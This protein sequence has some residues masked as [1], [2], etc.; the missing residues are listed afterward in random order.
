MSRKL[1]IY[2]AIVAVFLLFLSLNIHSNK[3]PANYRCEIHADKAGYYVYLPAL[4]LYDFNPNKFPKNIENTIGEGFAF[5]K[6]NPENDQKV[7]FTKYPCG[8]A[9]M[10][11][12][13]FLATHFFCTISN[14]EANGFSIP[15]HRMRD[16]ATCFYTIAGLF[17]VLLT[18]S[19]KTKLTEN[20]IILGVT[21]FILGTNFLYYSVKDVGL[22]HN[23]SFFLIALFVY[24]YTI[25]FN[26]Q[27]NYHY[28]VLAII[29][30][31]L[32][33]IR[34]INALFLCLI[35]LWDLNNP[36]ELKDRI[37]SHWKQ[38]LLFVFVVALMMLP[39]LAYYKYAFGSYFNYSYGNETFKYLR[40]PQ[41][42]K[43]FFG[44]QN[45]WITN[46]P[47]HIFTIIGI[48][49]FIRDGITN[50]WKLLTLVLAIGLLYSAWWS[51]GLG[52][53]F[54]HR[55][56]VEFYALLILPFIYCINVILGQPRHIKIVALSLLTIC[57][58][59]NLKLTFAYDNCWYG[60]SAWDIAEWRKL[61][62]DTGF[63]K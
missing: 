23:Y 30:G 36:N 44:L 42:L 35:G 37:L 10:D 21:L 46:N 4:F 20:T 39:Q 16:I 56:F 62:F 5:I 47:I 57:I 7:I 9:I 63:V 1:T 18:I 22:S 19:R 33:L 58:G 54:G 14:I 8:V 2:L 28:V 32:L 59:I 12:P 52:C 55:G 49:L 24:L 29:I 60:S 6:K 17:F 38:W 53:G 43:V 50:G 15:Y 48:L 27:K 11:A 34:P 13:F 61:M 40:N 3:Q 51:W 25:R 31:L 41:L 45:G 26:L